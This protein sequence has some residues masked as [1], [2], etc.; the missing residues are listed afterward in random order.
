MIET[1]SL[2]QIDTGHIANLLA[3]Y[4][5]LIEFGLLLILFFA[6]TYTTLRYRFPGRAGTAISAVTALALAGS[7]AATMHQWGI[8]FLSSPWPPAV[9][10]SIVIMAML[11]RRRLPVLAQASPATAMSPAA[12]PAFTGLLADTRAGVQSNDQIARQIERLS[13][14]IRDSD[15]R[16]R[17]IQDIRRDLARLLQ[18]ADITTAQLQHLLRTAGRLER[19]EAGSLGRLARRASKPDDSAPTAVRALRLQQEEGIRHLARSAI[20]QA[21][22]LRRS[23]IKAEHCLC[24]MD[25][26]DAERWMADA[27]NHGR[28]LAAVLARIDDV[29]RRLAAEGGVGRG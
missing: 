12:R 14:V 7:F 26:K 1:N 24:T 13:Q 11:V 17:E 6:V 10:I 21:K 19:D 5:S 25:P 8:S 29:E 22:R 28:K 18:V 27:F 2:A 20:H 4:Q 15:P 9:A 3:E 23:I 16:S